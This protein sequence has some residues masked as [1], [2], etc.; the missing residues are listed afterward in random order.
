L[1]SIYNSLLQEKD[2][3]ANLS[4]L[5]AALREGGQQ[6]WEEMNTFVAGHEEVFL[7][8][9]ASEDAKTRKNAALLLGDLEYEQALDALYQ[10][11]R[12]EE[13]R[14]VRASYLDAMAQMDVSQI[15]PEL[16]AQMNTLLS[17][18][19]TE[20]NR[21]HIEE[22][23]RALRNVLMQ[24]EGIVRHTFEAQGK[25]H[26]VLLR[27]NREQREIVKKQVEHTKALAKVHPLGVLVSTEDL[28]ALL[29][30]RTYRE[31]LFPIPVRPLPDQKTVAD[32]WK[33]MLTLCKKYH[34]EDGPFYFRVECRSK[35]SLEERSR[36]TKRLGARLEQL[37]GGELINST[38]DYEVELRLI[39][40][41]DGVFFPCLKFYTLP[42]LRFA[43]RKHA[44]ASSIHPS[45]AAL[46]MEL[47]APYLKE[48]AQV[49]DPFCG[50]GTML[51]VRDIRV[52]AKDKYGTDIYG[53]AI[54]G[55]RHNAS[56]AGEMIHFIHRDFFDF[57]HDYLFDEIVTN[58]PVRGRMTKEELD[59]LYERF[60]Q[61]ALTLL[62]REAVMILYTEE[63]GFV[64][65]QL[66]LH[67]EFSLLQEF[68]MQEKSGFY[69]LI[70]GVKK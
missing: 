46:M 26:Q 20:D 61:K 22:E 8:F 70:I 45:R 55:A 29:Q 37:S 41:Q 51:I 10:A 52:P 43:Y 9:L 19:L 40:G 30:I 1:E 17:V 2:V 59:G 50:V 25:K 33:P 42:D 28:L 54:T 49:L 48:G 63:L 58:M 67:R 15:L 31:M 13:T 36:F 34:R 4:K 62:A 18:E 64:K 24:Y 35:L 12:A 7:H 68:C 6:E 69:L 65:K 11:Y 57:R 38:G 21:K 56:L 14:F 32:L 23:I 47:A 5:R 16:K 44:I 53:E 3:R 66:R 60:F 39:A 27:T